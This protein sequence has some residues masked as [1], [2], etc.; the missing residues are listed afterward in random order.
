MVFFV[1]NSRIFYENFDAYCFLQTMYL[2]S[3]CTN[4]F[5]L[6]LLLNKSSL[7]IMKLMP[8]PGS[9]VPLVPKTIK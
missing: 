2:I 3:G 5:H 9:I 4:M 7:K 1:T 6:C 8:M